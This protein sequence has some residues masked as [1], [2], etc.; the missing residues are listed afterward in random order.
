MRSVAK[1]SSPK[2]A[3]KKRFSKKKHGRDRREKKVGKGENMGKLKVIV[4]SSNNI[5]HCARAVAE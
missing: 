4:A 1:F 3:Q 2:V 5:T